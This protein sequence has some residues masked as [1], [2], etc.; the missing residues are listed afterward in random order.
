MFPN[1]AI[2]EQDVAANSPLSDSGL[3]CAAPPNETSL[4]A[5]LP[6]E[7]EKRRGG[8]DKKSHKGGFMFPPITSDRLAGFTRNGFFLVFQRTIEMKE[9]GMA[10]VADEG[11]THCD[12]IN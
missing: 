11:V 2:K 8:R 10:D 9:Q 5:I 4:F 1:S 7:C 3:G 6:G 12:G